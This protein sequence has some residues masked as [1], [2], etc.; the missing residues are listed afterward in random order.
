MSQDLAALLADWPYDPHEMN[1]R[2]IPGAD[3]ATVVQMRLELGVLQMSLSGRPDGSRP[4]GAESLLD[5][6]EADA[7]RAGDELRLAAEELEE[8]HREGQQYYKR[9]LAL[10]HLEWFEPVARDTERNLRLLDFVRRHARRKKDVWRFDQYRPY[11]LMMAARARGQL[12]LRA[13]HGAGALQAIERSCAGIR[14]FLAHYG[15]SPEDTA[16]GELEFLLRWRR[17]VQQGLTE[18]A[19]DGELASLERGLHDAVGREDYE[20]AA[21]FRDRIRTLTGAVPEP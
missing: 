6:L 10:F 15:R 21:R 7:A 17:E 18:P 11:L 3:G 20:A 12:E 19:P 1:V 4:R 14:A 8:L 2:L 16:C 5:A 13:G 9:Y